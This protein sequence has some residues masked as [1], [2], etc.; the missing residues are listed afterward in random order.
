MLKIVSKIRFRDQFIKNKILAIYIPLIII[1]LVILGY[2][3]N[4]FFMQAIINKTIKNVLDDSKLIIMQIESI[5]TDAESCA[6][7]TSLDLNR[8]IY[9]TQDLED[10]QVNNLD[11]RNQIQNQLV[12]SLMIFNDV[13]SISFIDKNSSLYFPN[14]Q[15]YNKLEEGFDKALHSSVL[16]DINKTNGQNIWL[17]MQV[18]D[19]LTMDKKAYVLTLGKSIIN[20]STGSKLG[21]LLLNIK[22]DSL[23]SIYKNVG[24][25]S[26]R[27]Y[28]IVDQ[29]GI[30]ISSI[31]K[32][33][34]L[35]KIDDKSLMEKVL[36]NK[37]FTEIRVINGN[38]TLVTSIPFGKTDWKLVNEIP[39]EELTRDTGKTTIM[40]ILIGSICL[41]FALLGAG[42]LSRVIANPIVKLTKSMTQIKQGNLNV[43]CMVNS[44]DEIGL[45]ASGFNTMVGTIKELLI[46]IKAE[47]KNKREYELALIQA[48]IKPHFLY[49]TLDTIFTLSK[50]GKEKE[51]QRATKALADFYRIALS[52][53][54]EIIS[55]DEEI[56]NV[57]SYLSIQQ[58]RYSDIFD[59]EINV[60]E[61][62]TRYNILKLTIQPLV[63]NSIYHGLKEKGSFGKIAVKGY[64]VA[65]NIIIKVIDDGIG[66]TPEK[67]D[68]ILR[69]KESESESHGFGLRSVNEM[70]KLYFGD[71]YGINVKSVI[72]TGTE[73][74]ITIPIYL[75]GK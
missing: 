26:R 50:M 74:T 5:M 28:Y 68:N 52:K 63:E 8:N 2:V 16:R 44:S 75:E 71:Q 27:D 61:D 70:I 73:V 48:Q 13:E 3:S 15:I 38:K 43:N 10:N 62:L 51:V 39:L 21:V 55:I 1:P 45:L 54:K 11:L 49:N 35:K 47:Q 23:S 7:I 60:Q 20:I 32:R 24:P 46:N 18:R 34:I 36:A 53:G 64:R 42:I 56:K 72:G 30:I 29:Q 37:T 57:T 14:S 66:M 40:I 4:Y 17:P 65:D 19:F 58:I 25:V 6:N 69:P 22:E 67:L 9:K 12:F 33:L 31:K 41:F 59:F